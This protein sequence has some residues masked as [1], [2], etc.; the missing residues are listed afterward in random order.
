M[1]KIVYGTYISEKIKDRIKADVDKLQERKQRLP[2]LVVILIGNNQA[3]NAYVNGKSKDC[4]E[5]GILNT[6]LRYDDISEDELLSKI[7][8]LNTDDTVDGILVQ[9]PLPKHIDEKRVIEAISPLKDVDGFHMQNVGKLYI[10][11]TTFVP[12]TPKGIIRILEEIGLDNLQ[13]KKLLFWEEVTLLENLSQ[14][15]SWIK[16]QLLQFVILKQMIF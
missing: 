15:F 7:R 10:G 4:E 14:N 3:S 9:L 1:E 6:T 12:C 2:K 11:D 13:G 16:M 8:E 5:V